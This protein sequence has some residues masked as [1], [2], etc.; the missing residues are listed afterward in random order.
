MFIKARVGI[1]S[2]LQIKKVDV[3][4]Y[5]MIIY[6]VWSGIKPWNG[7]ESVDI[8]NKVLANLRPEIPDQITNESIRDLI[9]ACWQE[10]PVQRPSFSQIVETVRSNIV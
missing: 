4:A 8:E 1:T 7:L 10:D 6:Q 3:Y 9:K 2:A 5:A